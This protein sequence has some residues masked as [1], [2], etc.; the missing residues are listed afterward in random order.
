MLHK[1]ALQLAD[2]L[3]KGGVIDAGSKD[4][5]VYGF[6]LLISFLFSTSLVLIAGVVLGKV[7]ETAAFLIVYILLRSYSG[8][9]HANSYAVCTVVTLSVYFAVILLSSFVNV[10]ITAYVF[11]MFAGLVLLALL[12]PVRNEHKK[13][14]PRDA[15]KY[16][17]I[18]MGLYSVFSALGIYVMP[19]NTC[20]GNS[21]FYTLCAD[22]INLFPSCIHCNKNQ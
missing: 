22:L 7:P 1:T 19:R 21:V 3:L 8:G 17:M 5:C 11:L 14:S 18:S 12:A 2:R 9:Y 6:E 4:I 16:K 13:I 10:N 15:W 20:L